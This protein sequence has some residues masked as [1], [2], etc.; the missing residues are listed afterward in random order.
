MSYSRLTL[1]AILVLFLIGGSVIFAP[2]VATAQDASDAGAFTVTEVLPAADSQGVATDSTIVVIFNRPVVPLVS[3]A[4]AANLPNPLT[5]SPAVEGVGEWVNT[6][7][8]SFS[9]NSPLNGSQSYTVSV[10]ASLTT[11]DGVA[12]SEPFSWPFSTASLSVAEIVPNAGASDVR[13][14]TS[15]QVRFNQPVDRQIAESNFSLS[16]SSQIE[17]SFEWAEDS[18]GFR[19]IPAQNLDFSQSYDV[20]FSGEQEPSTGV[21]GSFTTIPLPS[22]LSTEPFDGQLTARATGS[23]VVYYA[24]PMDVTTLR[25]TISIDPMPEG[26]FDTY[27]SE[28]NNAYYINVNTAPSTEYT[29]TLAPGASDIFGNVIETETVVRFTTEALSP[30]ISLNSFSG[31]GF[32]NAHNEQTRL[33]LTHRNVS[34]VD[35]E[36]YRVPTEDF[37]RQ[38]TGEQYYNPTLNF[39]PAPGN[40]LR[41]WSISAE[42]TPLNANRYEMLNL[43]ENLN[44]AAVCEGAPT[45]RLHLGDTL[46]VV[47]DAVRVRATPPSGEILTV[48]Y[49]NFTAPIIGGVTCANN[50]AWWQIQLPDGRSGWVAEGVEGEYYLDVEVAAQTA[51]DIT[52]EDGSALPPGVYFLTASEPERQYTVEHF[53]VV[54]TTNITMKSAQDSLLLWATDVTSGQ[55]VTEAPISIYDNAL[56]VVSQVTSDSDGL[57]SAEYPQTTDLYVPRVAVL[58]DGD[59]FGIGLNSWAEGI[60]GYQFDLTTNYYP[61]NYSVYLYTDRPIYREGQDVHFRGV[62]R[63]RDDMQYMPPS[64]DVLVRI[65]DGNG[66]VVYEQSLSLSEYGTFNDTFTLAED[67]GLG[68]YTLAAVIDGENSDYYGRSG[69]ISFNVADYR[70]PEFQV[71]LTPETAEVVRGDTIRVTL[72]STYFFGG[73]VQNADV[74]YSVIANISAIDFLDNSYSFV[75]YSDGAT[76]SRY[77]GMREVARGD[78]VTDANGQFVIEIPSIVEDADQTLS[79]DFEATVTDQSG[80]AVAGRASVIVHQGLIYIGVKPDL[81]VGTADQSNLIN[82]IA[83]DWAGEA[84]ANQA[85][86]I[87]VV[88]QRWSSVQE[89][90]EYGRAIWTTELEEISVT[91]GDVVTDADGLA[92]YSFIPPSAGIYKVTATSTDSAGNQVSSASTVWVSGSGYVAWNLQNS[93]R[94]DL[95]TDK[96]SYQVGDTAEILITSP[97]QGT[98][99]ALVTVERDSV[100][101]AERIVIDSN[102][103]VYSLPIT[104]DYAPN[105]F[106]S[107]MLVKGIDENNPVASFRMGLAQINV[108]IE[109]KELTLNVET[110]NA[111]AGPGDTVTFT[112]TALDYEGNPVSNAEIGASLSDLAVLSLAE[113]NSAPILTYYYSEQGLSVRTSTALTI[114]TD[115]LTQTTLDTIKGGGG[116]GGGLG[117]MGIFE[118][119]EDFVDTAYWNA[120]AVTD[121]NGQ[122]TF[123]VTLPDNLTTWVLDAR[124]VTSGRDGEMLVGQITSDL[125]S[126][127]P[128]LVRPVTPRFFVAGDQLE[129]AA[130]VNNNTDESIAAEVYFEG[131]GLNFVTPDEPVLRQV[132]IAA[133]TSERVSWHV[134]VIDSLDVE[135]V[136]LTFYVSGGEYTDAAKPSFG[137]GDGNLLPI[138]RFEVP[139]TV[140]TGGTLT[141]AQSV[142]ETINLPTSVPVYAATLDIRAEA[143]L[144]ASAL[145]SVQSLENMR[146]QSLE[147]TTSRLYANLALYGTLEDATSLTQTISESLQR[148][149]AEQKV[150]GG[151]GWFVQDQSNATV[152]AYALLSLVEAEQKGFSVAPEV[153][154]NARNY[155]RSTLIPLG[156]DTAQWQFNRQALTLYALTQANDPDVARTANLYENRASLAYYAQALLAMTV[157]QIDGNNTRANVLLSD[158][159]SNANISA[160]GARWQEAQRDPY[161]W[162]TN[163]RTTA[164][165]LE[166]LVS[167]NT[168]SPLIPNVVRGLMVARQSDVWETSQETAWAVNALVNYASASNDTAANY[169]YAI[170]LNDAQLASG[171]ASA[172]LTAPLLNTS[173]PLAELQPQNALT[174]TRED[175]MGALYYNANLSVYLPMTDVEAVSDGVIVQRHYVLLNDETETP[176]TEARVGDEIQV[177]LSIIAPNDLHYLV[178][179]DPLPAGVEAINPDLLT[180]TQVG[181]QPQISRDNPLQQGWGYWWF[182]NIEFRA[183]KVVMSATYLPA[184][185]YEFIYTMRAGIPGT[186]S[187]IPATAHETYFPDVYGRTEGSVFTIHP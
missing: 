102:S 136:D 64:G 76:S 71:A 5:F 125:L 79:F 126:T 181:T 74:Q 101:S 169:S 80:Q 160:T 91:E 59:Q 148:L 115:Q 180:S 89:V 100:L 113:P 61:Y 178:V 45:S 3:R 7:I 167:L 83:V 173:I 38:V 118:I 105:V 147:Q 55:P 12:L 22:V 176:I 46:R 39:I 104:A 73:R 135:N 51:V 120:S 111:Q 53:L 185:T 108:D 152:T 31:I 157:A 85:I 99:E 151:W 1:L 116:G 6:S 128:L 109:Q 65:T 19:F 30:Q 25:D 183:E 26:A 138:Y 2:M 145:N 57:A 130:I 29:V 140:V 43:G 179:E 94:I 56:S 37:L 84:I 69:S 60:E 88:E 154:R 110:D 164:I 144:I 36:L 182:S 34:Q 8:Y 177:R 68:Y 87:Q 32:Y 90:D 139:E 41:R 75:N 11:V 44:S 150:D 172:D 52:A 175:G 106:V 96:T 17:G 98:V 27:Y 70:A 13:V 127:K 103:Y 4:E 78:G 163:T 132:T 67:S 21:I 48:V 93:N 63:I 184:G 159:V 82:L 49:E 47:T 92:T 42:E 134:T 174:I 10:D 161:N 170:T 33:F 121:A 142:T 131:T 54:G 50:L 158:L 137:Q 117:D 123:S 9:P 166:A 155:L 81:Y 107:V 16:A 58:D 143:S 24:S 97:Y 95:I 72:D 133:G 112:I 15:I 187:V 141:E 62:A 14:D 18:A 86:D 146:Y 129:I 28:Y 35:L 23:F 162:N 165:I 171:T 124:A 119:R 153:L 156:L 149:F 168:Q 122:V 77:F 114:N 66:N 40:L 186:F 20:G